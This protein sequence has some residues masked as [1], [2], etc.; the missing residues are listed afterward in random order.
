M[1]KGVVAKSS[2]KSGPVRAPTTGL[3]ASSLLVAPSLDAIDALDVDTLVIC[4]TP[5]M[6]PLPG[7][8]G[9]CDWRLCGALSNLIKRGILSGVVD[10]KVLMPGDRINIPRLLVLGFGDDPRKDSAQKLEWLSSTTLAL[11]AERIAVAPPEPGKDWM[12]QAEQALTKAFGD[13]LVTLF[14]PER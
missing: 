7:A 4:L 3:P 2:A 12:G 11:G 6:R 1:G 9:F 13:R 10:E 5:S 8:A 14:E